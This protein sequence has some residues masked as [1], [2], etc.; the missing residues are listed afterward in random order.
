MGDAQLRM[1][2]PTKMGTKLPKD[3]PHRQHL[4]ADLGC[5]LTSAPLKD[6]SSSN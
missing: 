3:D 4:A 1:G 5:H 6:T 2:I